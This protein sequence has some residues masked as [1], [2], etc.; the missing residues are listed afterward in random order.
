MSVQD[1]LIL[2]RPHLVFLLVPLD[3]VIAHEDVALEDLDVFA[4]FV[5]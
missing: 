5:G 3:I 2:N 4:V 1:V